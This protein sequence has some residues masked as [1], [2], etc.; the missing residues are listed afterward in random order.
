ML[1]AATTELDTTPTYESYCVPRPARHLTRVS[2][3]PPVPLGRDPSHAACVVEERIEL[4]QLLPVAQTHTQLVRH[5]K[6]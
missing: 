6:L 4:S 5:D 1:G 3:N 2:Q